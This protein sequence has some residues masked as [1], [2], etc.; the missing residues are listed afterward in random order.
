MILGARLDGTADR[1]PLATESS[2]V[3]DDAL[4]DVSEPD[5]DPE[6]ESES[7]LDPDSSSDSGGEGGAGCAFPDFPFVPPA[8]ELAFASLEACRSALPRVSLPPSGRATDA[9]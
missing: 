9:G 6:S 1:P 7:V 2:E 4:L 3:T 8:L 5:P